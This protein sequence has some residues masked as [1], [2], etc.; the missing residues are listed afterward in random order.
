VT[1][2]PA[3]SGIHL[4]CAP[5]PVMRLDPASLPARTFRLRLGIGEDSE[6][7]PAQGRTVNP[8][9]PTPSV[10]ASHPAYLKTPSTSAPFKSCSTHTS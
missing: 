5:S 3:H 2:R 4:W 9:T 6:K 7:P 10:P 8:I 1:A